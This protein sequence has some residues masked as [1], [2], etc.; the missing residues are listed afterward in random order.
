MDLRSCCI[1]REVLSESHA[2]PRTSNRAAVTDER[3]TVRHHTLIPANLSM[4]NRRRGDPNLLGFALMPCYLRFPE[5]ILQQASRSSSPPAPPW[6]RR[7][8]QSTS[9][10]TRPS[11]GSR[12]LPNNSTFHGLQRAERPDAFAIAKGRTPGFAGEAVAV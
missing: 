10:R 11:A 5:R 8:W 3:G 7:R 4:I 1:V 6:A 9:P 2:N 12:Y